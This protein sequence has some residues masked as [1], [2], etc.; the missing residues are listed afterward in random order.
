VNYTTQALDAALS[1]NDDSFSKQTFIQFGRSSHM[2]YQDLFNARQSEV[3]AA[4]RT[5]EQRMAW[6]QIS[7]IERL[8]SALRAAK[9]HLPWNNS[10]IAVK[11]H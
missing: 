6:D 5:I 11:A 3:H 7:R 4:G 2:L 1:V 9:V 8:E 10:G